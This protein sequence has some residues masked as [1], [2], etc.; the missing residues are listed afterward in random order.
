[1]DVG[2]VAGALLGRVA[3]EERALLAEDVLRWRDAGG[4][5]LGLGLGEGRLG[6]GRVADGV[7]VDGGAGER[8]VAGGGVE[9]AAAVVP[10]AVGAARPRVVV[11]ERAR[12]EAAA[13]RERLRRVLVLV[14][15]KKQNSPACNPPPVPPPGSR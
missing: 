12:V 6:G 2:K 14:P 13:L 5:A 10:E 9:R 8:G 15:G 11:V 1:V 3:L 4:D 7:V